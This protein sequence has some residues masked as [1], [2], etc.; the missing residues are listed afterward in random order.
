MRFT[1][2]LRSLLLAATVSQALPAQGLMPFTDLLP[3]GAGMLAF[4]ITAPTVTG[5]FGFLLLAPERAPAALPT[6]FGALWLLPPPLLLGAVALT[7]SGT[8]SYPLPATTPPFAAAFQAVTVDPSM[9]T[10]ALT[11][12]ALAGFSPVGLLSAGEGVAGHYDDRTQS[13]RVDV[14]GQPGTWVEINIV[15]PAN[16]HV[17]Q[18][19]RA[20]IQPNGELT[21]QGRITP[22]GLGAGN[23][24]EV[25]V[26]GVKKLEL[27]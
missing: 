4:T 16:N 25:K 20:Q 5:G 23:H 13:W 9:T 10:F 11:N 18:M 22:G 7:P 19:V 2:T 14:I 8:L 27:K 12:Y 6:P 24:L 17:I 21:L 3:G 1:S 15:E 26:G